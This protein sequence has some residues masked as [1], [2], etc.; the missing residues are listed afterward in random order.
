MSNISF[1][2][3]SSVDAYPGIRRKKESRKKTLLLKKTF[4]ADT[5]YFFSV[6]VEFMFRITTPYATNY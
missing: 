4:L 3:S 2:G 5:T 1:I 6:L